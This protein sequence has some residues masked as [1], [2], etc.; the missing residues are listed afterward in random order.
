MPPH[1]GGLPWANFAEADESD[2][3]PCILRPD[4]QRT[5]DCQSSPN[6]EPS[7]GVASIEQSYLPDLD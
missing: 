7:P 4:F 2:C 3:P 6:S 1:F 5:P